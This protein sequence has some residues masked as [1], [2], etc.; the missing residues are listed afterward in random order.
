MASV[1]TELNA[2]LNGEVYKHSTEV[3]TQIFDFGA[4]VKLSEENEMQKAVK[5]PTL[6]IDVEKYRENSW[7][8]EM[9]NKR[10]MPDDLMSKVSPHTTTPYVD[11]EVLS[12]GDR[13][14]MKAKLLMIKRHSVR[15]QHQ[16][17]TRSGKSRRRPLSEMHKDLDTLKRI[18][19]EANDICSELLKRK[20]ALLQVVR[21]QSSGTEKMLEQPFDFENMEICPF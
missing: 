16:Q 9:F 20:E 18:C 1:L 19:G 6:S 10:F 15:I 3:K 13:K 5:K 2:I 17:F 21:A 11:L 14:Q 7:S 4:V 8:P 12:L